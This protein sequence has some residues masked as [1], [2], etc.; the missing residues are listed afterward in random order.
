MSHEKETSG[1]AFFPVPLEENSPHAGRDEFRQE[2]GDQNEDLLQVLMQFLESEQ[3]LD[4][5]CAETDTK[6]SELVRIPQEKE[7][8]EAESDGLLM[9]EDMVEQ[10]DLFQENNQ[11]LNL[12]EVFQV[13]SAEILNNEHQDST[14]GQ[15][16]GEKKYL[17]M[18]ENIERGKEDIQEMEEESKSSAPSKTG[19][20]DIKKQDKRGKCCECNKEYVHISQHS[21]NKHNGKLEKCTTSGCK[22]YFSSVQK[23]FKHEQREHRERKKFCCQ[24]C[25]YSTA[26]EGNLKR[27]VR[28]KHSEKK[29]KCGQRKCGK[30]FASETDLK[31]HVK[32]CHKMEKCPTCGREMSLAAFK[33][34]KR[35]GRCPG[36]AAE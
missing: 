36:T 12:E 23:R 26:Q 14:S 1:E 27:H 4:L 10:K 2:E 33:E 25:Y 6:S 32:M 31:Q 3:V 22:I 24:L 17:N 30:M 19:S 7:S 28:H 5:P 21:R 8:H 13:H 29:I 16:S 35:W 11:F 15:P 9:L 20:N 34:H 18:K